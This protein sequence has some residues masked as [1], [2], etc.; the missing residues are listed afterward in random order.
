[1]VR[2]SNAFLSFF[3]LLSLQ[4]CREITSLSLLICCNGIETL[5]GMKFDGC[6]VF[7]FVHFFGYL[8]VQGINEYGLVILCLLLPLLGLAHILME[9]IKENQGSTA[10][11]QQHQL[12]STEN[13]ESSKEENLAAK[14]CKEP[15]HQSYDNRAVVSSMTSWALDVSLIC[16]CV[17]QTM[18]AGG[19][20]CLSRGAWLML[21]FHILHDFVA[22]PSEPMKI[23]IAIYGFCTVCLMSA[24]LVAVCTS[25]FPLGLWLAV[26]CLPCVA[27]L[28][29]ITSCLPVHKTRKPPS[30]AAR[31]ASTILCGSMA[32]AAVC[33]MSDGCCDLVACQWF[34]DFNQ[35]LSATQQVIFSYHSCWLESYDVLISSYSQMGLVSLPLFRGLLAILLLWSARIAR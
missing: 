24:V 8:F 20:A 10:E 22:P 28:T 2:R 18:I 11:E 27:I 13:N 25:Y 21:I 3:K 30:I 33:V 29:T 31:A 12:A 17:S 5:C 16:I 7:R 26:A 9:A 15:R 4:C 23:S 6:I 34:I 35:M 14:S 1:M 32:A 19:M